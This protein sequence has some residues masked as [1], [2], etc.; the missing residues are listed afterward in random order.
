MRVRMI[1]ISTKEVVAIFTVGG[2]ISEITVHPD[3]YLEEV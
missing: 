1:R 3:Y 2:D